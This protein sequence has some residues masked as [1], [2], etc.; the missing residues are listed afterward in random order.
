MNG[1]ESL[2]VKDN[3]SIITNGR[4]RKEM[5]SATNAYNETSVKLSNYVLPIPD[6]ETKYN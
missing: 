1:G 2:S 3:Y 5:H 4:W 6:G